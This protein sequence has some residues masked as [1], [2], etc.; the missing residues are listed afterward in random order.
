MIKR[1]NNEYFCFQ[2]FLSSS[3]GNRFAVLQTLVVPEFGVDERD[4]EEWD[5][6]RVVE[7]LQANSGKVVEMLLTVKNI[8]IKDFREMVNSKGIS[9]HVD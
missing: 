3:N 1:E 7:I 9:F 6:R 5:R 4:F 2:G 8:K